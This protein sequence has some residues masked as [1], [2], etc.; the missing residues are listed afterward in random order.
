[1]KRGIQFGLVLAG[2]VLCAWLGWIT[3]EFRKQSVIEVASPADVIGFM[4]AAAYRG[5]PSPVLRARLDHGLEL[6]EQGLA[7]RILTTG[8]AGAGPGFTGGAGGR[9]YLMRRGGPPAARR[10]GGGGDRPVH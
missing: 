8:G 1:M 5:R 3:V 7:R 10:R 4:G 6:F 9:N 2:T